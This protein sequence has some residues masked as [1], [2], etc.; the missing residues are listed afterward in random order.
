MERKSTAL[1]TGVTGQ[2]GSYLAELLVASG[3]DVVGVVR[4]GDT[5]AEALIERT[6]DVTLIEG[7]LGD[8]ARLRAIVLDVAPDAV[9]NLGGLT[10]VAQSWSDP[11]ASATITGLSAAALL[12]AAWAVQT[13]AGRVVHFV[14]ASS[15]EIFGVPAEHPQSESTAVQPI[16]PYGAAKAYAHFL[17]GAYRTLGLAASSCILYNHESPRRPDT[18]VTRK[19]TMAVARISLGLQ[20]KLALGSLDV[21]RDW[22]WAPDYAA[23]I[24]LVGG[25]AA[26][27]FVVAT[28]ASHSV[29]DFVSS[30]FAAV[31]IDD[32]EKYVELDPAFRRPAEAAELV[33][34]STRIRT[35]LGWAPTVDFDELVARMVRHDLDLESPFGYS[36]AG[37]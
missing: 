6:P 31:G 19:I 30:A 27:D 9:Y 22:G 2:T 4:G 20:D 11:L 21:R 35:R 23:A 37:G 34:D 16:N 28:G 26:E 7:D 29:G 8:P 5:A 12:D 25:S 24:A 1:V 3:V 33:G 15:A 36:P 32:W 18:F 17:V 10:S 13:G 14:Q